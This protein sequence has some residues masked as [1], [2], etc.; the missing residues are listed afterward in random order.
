MRGFLDITHART[1]VNPLA[2]IALPRDQKLL[3]TIDTID[4]GYWNLKI[5]LVGVY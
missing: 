2:L 3:E 1:S 5:I 4:P